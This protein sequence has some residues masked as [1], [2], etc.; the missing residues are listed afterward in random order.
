MHIIKNNKIFSSK[1]F[2]ILDFQR[3]IKN[4]T[5]AA[6]SAF[7]LRHLRHRLLKY[8]IKNAYHCSCVNVQAYLLVFR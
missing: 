5:R 3:C 8:V 2:L 6:R 4:A 7:A 1:N